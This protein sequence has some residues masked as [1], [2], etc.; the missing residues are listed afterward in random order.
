MFFC[1]LDVGTSGVKAVVFDELGEIKAN[2]FLAY[3]LE[4]RADGTRDLMADQIWDKTKKVLSQAVSICPEVS[5][6]AVS[7]FGEAFVPV[8]KT[9]KELSEVI[10]LTDRRGEKEFYAAKT[11]TSDERIAELIGVPPSTMYSLPKLL[12]IKH[13]RPDV[14]EKAYKFLLIEDYIY[15]KLSGLCCFYLSRHTRLLH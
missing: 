5:S 9:G 15:F 10:L 1:G 4:L 13:Q 12:Y 6:L 8:D 7:S 2:C 3:E 14:Y 11:N